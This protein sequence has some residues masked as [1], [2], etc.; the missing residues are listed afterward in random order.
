MIIF[1]SKLLLFAKLILGLATLSCSISHINQHYAT[2]TTIGENITKLPDPEL[3]ITTATFTPEEIQPNWEDF[4]AYEIVDVLYKDSDFVFLKLKLDGKYFWSSP[5]MLQNIEK[6]VIQSQN[7]VYSSEGVYYSPFGGQIVTYP[8]Q[9]V[10]ESGIGEHKTLISETSF[11]ENIPYYSEDSETINWYSDNKYLTITCSP[12]YGTFTTILIDVV[13]P[14]VLGLSS[15]FG[16]FGALGINARVSN[17][18][19]YIF[20]TTMGECNFILPILDLYD[21]SKTT[22][23]IMNDRVIGNSIVESANANV[24]ICE[25]DAEYLF[26]TFGNDS[27]NLYIWKKSYDK[28][29]GDENGLYVYNIQAKSLQKVELREARKLINLVKLWLENSERRSGDIGW[30][31]NEKESKFLLL[32]F[33]DGKTQ[34]IDVYFNKIN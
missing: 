34:Y 3:I 5:M 17:N 28:A 20:F 9:L 15:T 31:L 24:P 33:V 11:C 18:G 10:Y 16:K 8:D 19:N 25:S 27:K 12:Q 29:K 21:E 26:P 2:P 6:N 14:N 22:T 23:Q 1:K 32:R 4:T 7:E 30:I 13:K